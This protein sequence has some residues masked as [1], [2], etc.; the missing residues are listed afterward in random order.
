MHEFIEFIE[1]I[2][3]TEFIENL[4]IDLDTPPNSL[5]LPKIF[6]YR[7]GTKPVQ[8]QVDFIRL[9]SYEDTHSTGDVRVVGID[10]LQSLSG[11]VCM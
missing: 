6:N 1:F 4:H 5:D 7:L 9:K 10:N 3:F 11:K 8:L 2:V